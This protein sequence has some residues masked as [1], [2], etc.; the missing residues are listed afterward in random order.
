MKVALVYPPACDP[1]APYLSLPTLAAQ[2]R[3]HGVDVE[4]VDANVEAFDWLLSRTELEAQARRV[5]HRFAELS[6][7]ASLAHVEALEY[8]ALSRALPLLTT[9]PERI[10]E[11]KRSL[12]TMDTFFDPLVY[13]EATQLIDGGLALASASHSPL[14][15]DF[16]TY[17]TPFS[18]LTMRDVEADS[19]RSRNPFFDWVEGVLGPRL[20]EARV[21]LVGLSVCFPGQLQPAYAFAHQLRRLLPGVHLTVGGPGITQMTPPPTRSRHVT[22]VDGPSQSQVEANLRALDGMWEDRSRDASRLHSRALP[23]VDPRVLRGERP[24]LQQRRDGRRRR[25]CERRPGRQLRLRGLGWRAHHDGRDAR[26]NGRGP[27]GH[28]PDQRRPGLPDLVDAGGHS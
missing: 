21:E 1:T 5:E 16:T 4:L 13:D 28:H 2:L 20:A 12:R 23:L 22:T 11:A 8:G 19:A 25:R 14:K 6:A 17:R 26:W 27:R 18:M 7:R 24:H 9:V 10:D 15:M 3:G